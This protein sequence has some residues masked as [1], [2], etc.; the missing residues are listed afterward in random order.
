MNERIQALAKQ[1]GLKY[2]IELEEFAR[3]VIVQYNKEMRESRRATKSHL[4]YSRI[5]LNNT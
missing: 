3:L 4:G 2:Q 1:A 5:G